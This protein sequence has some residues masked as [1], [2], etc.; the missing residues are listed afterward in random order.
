MATYT[1][2]S[3][4]FSAAE[5][6]GLDRKL[7]YRNDARAKQTPPVAPQ[8][9]QQYLDS[10]AQAWPAL[11]LA[12]FRADLKD[13]CA[14]AIN[15]ANVATLTTVTNALAVPLNPYSGGQVP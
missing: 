10:L 8:T 12:E 9:K 6:A 1:L 3:V 4:T 2:A 11:F 7:A 5:E 13:R 14:T 15:S